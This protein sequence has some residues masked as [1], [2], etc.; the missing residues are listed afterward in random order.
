M[1]RAMLMWLVAIIVGMAS[2]NA[3]HAA[4]VPSPAA[5]SW[6]RTVQREAHAVWGIT[7]PVS[8]FG[9]QIE[10]ES[11]W[12]PNARSPYAG[13]LAQFTADTA[14]DMA[15]WYPE[16]GPAD[17]YDPRW[18]IRALVRYDYRLYNGVL[19]A[20]SEC[21]HW[22][23]TLSA[24]NGGAGWLSRDRALCSR[25]SACDPSRWWGHVER[26]SQRASWA[27]TENRAYPSRIL[28]TLQAPY[29]AAGWAGQAVCP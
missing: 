2:L 8:A 22:A 6:Q 1:I 3:A 26:Q 24:Y 7:A 20:R 19:G 13:G 5:K 4:S 25:V 15:R 17:P 10:Q 12:R 29:A 21:D 18:A 23:M 9:A 16:L 11:A 14:S 28:L 27:L